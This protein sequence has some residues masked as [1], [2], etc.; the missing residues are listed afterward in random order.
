[1]LKI[2]DQKY[3]AMTVGGNMHQGGGGPQRRRAAVESAGRH[4]GRDQGGRSA[5]PNPARR[6]CS[7]SWSGRPRFSRAATRLRACKF[8][9]ML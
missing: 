5:S 4:R 7:N 3:G 6:S 2:S 8:G 9:T 1:M